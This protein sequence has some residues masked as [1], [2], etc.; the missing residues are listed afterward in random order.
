MKELLT[1]FFAYGFAISLDKLL[2]FLLIPI[3][4]SK[5]SVD[6]FGVID[7]IQTIIGIVSIFAFLQ[8]ETSL[9]R[10]YFEYEGEKK[11][12]YVFTIYIS[13]I[14]LSI[15]LSVLIGLFSRILATHI[16]GDANYYKY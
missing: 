9:Q 15:L 6:E 3:Y 8:L 13:V 1:N 5:L 4:A 2:A 10:Y 11:K 14:I 7:L 16:C 12:E